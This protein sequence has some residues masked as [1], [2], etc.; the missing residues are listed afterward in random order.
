MT[1][2]VFV[3]LTNALELLECSLAVIVAVFETPFPDPMKIAN[4]FTL[5]PVFMR[6]EAGAGTT[7]VSLLVNVTI[8]LCMAA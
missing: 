8:W 1:V 3:L 2:K 5:S 7:V 6:N 4:A